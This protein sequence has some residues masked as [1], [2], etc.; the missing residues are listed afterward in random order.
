MSCEIVRV[1]HSKGPNFDFHQA[2]YIFDIY[3]IKKFNLNL[4]LLWNI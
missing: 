3:K 1:Y 2:K 4:N